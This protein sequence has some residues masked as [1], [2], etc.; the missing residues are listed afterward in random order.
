MPRATDAVL[1]LDL[2][3]LHKRRVTLLGD[4]YRSVS[5]EQRD[6]VDGHAC[7]Q[8]LD[9]EGVPEHVGM[10]ALRRAV[11]LREIDQFEEAA[12][13]ALPVGNHALRLSVAAP[14]KVAWIRLRTGWDIFERLDYVRRERY[15]DRRSGLGLIEQK[16]IAMKPM[17][18][19]SHR[20]SDAETA[21]AH[22]QR[23]GAKTGP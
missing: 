23:H 9:G 6:L 13:A 12:V 3:C 18:L 20:V 5:K 1:K 17:P 2:P 16:A 4:L 19:K 14:E 15:I 22:Q 11:G 8:H 21:P 10:A 7:K